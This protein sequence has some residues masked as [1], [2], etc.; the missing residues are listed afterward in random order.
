MSKAC[1][2]FLLGCVEVALCW[3]CAG[4]EEKAD[5][6]LA[7]ASQLVDSAHDAEQASYADAFELYKKALAKAETITAKY[8]SSQVANKLTQGEAKLGPYTLAELQGTIV[9]WTQSK[10]AAEANP[11]A[12]ALLVAGS[13]PT[14]TETSVDEDTGEQL[15]EQD[16]SEQQDAEEKVVA[17]TVLAGQCAQLLPIVA[18]TDGWLLAEIAHRCAAADQYEPALAAATLLDDASVKAPVLA[19]IA[20][21]YARAGQ[22]E[23]AAELLSQAIE[24]V[25]TFTN[26]TAVL[27]EMARKSAQAGQSE[28]A[29]QIAHS[30]EDGYVRAQLWAAIAYS[31]LQAGHDEQAL[32]AAEELADDSPDKAGVFTALARTA[33]AAG[34]YDR[35]LH[36]ARV[37]PYPNIQAN[38]LAELAKKAVAA[39]DKEQ[40]AELLSQLLQTATSQSVFVRVLVLAAVANAYTAL[41]Q[42]EQTLALLAQARQVAQ[43]V[44]DTA[45]AV[46]SVG[47]PLQA[48]ASAY[49]EAGLYAQALE[50]LAPLKGAAFAVAPQVFGEMMRKYAAAGQCDQAVE[51]AETTIQEAAHKV[52]AIIEV[53]GECMAAGHKEKA[54][55]IAS[56]ALQGAQGIKTNSV[57]V[58]QLVE[59]AG[60]YAKEDHREKAV[61]ILSQALQM[62]PTNTDAAVRT[63][64]LTAI[65]RTYAEVGYFDQAQQVANTRGFN[66]TGMLAEIAGWYMQTG[67]YD[68]AFQVATAGDSLPEKMLAEIARKYAQAGQYTQAREAAQN[69]RLDF[70]LKE[71]VLVEIAGMAAQAGHYDQAREIVQRT[72]PTG[73]QSNVLAEI[74]RAYAAAGYYDQAL[75]TIEI[76]PLADSKASVLADLA[77]KCAEAGQKEKASEILLQALQVVKTAEGDS[78]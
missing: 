35:A 60:R 40:I 51:L 20:N 49:V 14:F 34:H 58:S 44:V 46:P 56:R 45:G 27:T 17:Q 41:G 55:E 37:I 5:Q 68:Q 62:V 38:V 11:L 12:C 1:V 32:Q 43:P 26:S 48:I 3:G 21:S 30:I 76:M 74:A 31:S 13:M 69:I 18:K 50:I 66:R 4:P 36:V 53:A 75:Q 16:A 6:L 23:K 24:I 15:S 7:E 42:Q 78:A 71:Q 70:Q 28:Q 61:E 59:I 47:N 22:K 2:W 54:A 25:T 64:M 63:E 72:E 8:P 57:L 29:R 19:E 39:S 67:Q 65:A 77:G 9:P 73:F 33:I 52:I 10:A